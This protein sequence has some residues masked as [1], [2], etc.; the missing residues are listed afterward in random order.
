[1]RWDEIGPTDPVSYLIKSE[2]FRIGGVGFGAVTPPEEIALR[3]LMSHEDNSILLTELFNKAA[4]TGKLYALLGLYYVD[5][6]KFDQ[7]ASYLRYDSQMIDTQGGCIISRG[8]VKDVVN[9]IKSGHY[10]IDMQRDI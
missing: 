1:M 7:L 10:D 3:N 5:R 2:C 8:Y 4:I 6:Q 9:S